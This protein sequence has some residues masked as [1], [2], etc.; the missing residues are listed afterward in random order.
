[1]LGLAACNRADVTPS[2][3]LP[4]PDLRAPL[5]EDLGE[6]LAEG[7]TVEISHFG[8]F[9][10][11]ERPAYEGRNPRTGEIV[12]VEGRR[13]P[14]FKRQRTEV[15]A[16]APSCSALSERTA[17]RS[18]V[19]RTAVEHGIAATFGAIRDGGGAS[20]LF[21]RIGEFSSAHKRE[22]VGVNPLTGE[23]IRHSAWTTMTFRP[24]RAFQW[25]LNEGGWPRLVPR[26]AIDAFLGARTG[27]ALAG[28]NELV[29]RLERLGARQIKRAAR[30]VRL[31]ALLERALDMEVVAAGAMLDALLVDPDDL[32]R[33]LAE[34]GALGGEVDDDIGVP[35]TGGDDGTDVWAFCRH[36]GDQDPWVFLALSGHQHRMRLSD[37]LEAALLLAELERAAGTGTLSAFDAERVRQHI[38]HR[39]PATEFP[40][41]YLPY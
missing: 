29:V 40:I 7:A 8:S 18:G 41:G 5:A 15:G 22:Q 27:S 24:S 32:A 30:S 25:R 36:G 6:L 21:G 37:W 34:H 17:Q 14:F 33:A 35:F 16:P 10:V 9:L 23:E 39:F 13:L 31:P 4:P 26:S 20:V 11:R 38:A 1:M 19:E 3:P 28:E 12:K 2:S